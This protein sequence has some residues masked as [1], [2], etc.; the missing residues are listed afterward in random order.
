M[1]KLGRASPEVGIRVG[2]TGV[3]ELTTEGSGSGIRK[4]GTSGGAGGRAGSVSALEG[5]NV[6]E[7]DGAVYVGTDADA[8]G[9][10]GG[11]ATGVT[12]VASRSGG[13]ATAGAGVVGNETKLGVGVVGVVGEGVGSA[14]N[15]CSGAGG[16]AYDTDPAAGVIVGLG[17]GRVGCNWAGVYVAGCGVGETVTG[18]NCGFEAGA[19]SVMMYCGP[20]VVLTTESI[21][22]VIPGDAGI[23]M[24]DGAGEFIG[25]CPITVGPFCCIAMGAKPA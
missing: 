5:L 4:L 13:M 22:C 21:G 8:A 23:I 25:L 15:T 1:P 14:A 6:G 9:D 17:A 16:G 10:S 12:G 20:F 19:P 7:P 11:M 18:A 24:D 2:P 3:L